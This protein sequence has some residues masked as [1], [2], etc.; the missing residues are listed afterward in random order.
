MTRF[1]RGALTDSEILA[2]FREVAFSPVPEPNSL[3]LMLWGGITLWF[4]RRK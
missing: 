1:Y 2:N 3:V 4:M